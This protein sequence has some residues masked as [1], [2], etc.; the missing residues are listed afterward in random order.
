MFKTLPQ[1]IKVMSYK[2]PDVAAQYSKNSSDEFEAITYSQLFQIQLDVGAGLLQIGLKRG[3]HVGLISDTRK[4]W[5]HADLGLLSIGAIDVPRGCDATTKDLSYIL[6]FAECKIVIT[7]NNTQVA[8]IISIS[9][10]IPTL[11]TIIFFDKIDENTENL[12]K[13]KKLRLIPFDQIISSGAEWRK[14][15]PGAIEAEIE[16]GDT[17]DLASIIFT[18]GTTGEPKGV[19]L[20]HKNFI[21]QLDELNEN[22][23]FY[24]GEKCISVLPV[25]HA[26]ERLCEYV[27]LSQAAAICYSKPIGSVLL[28]DLEKLNPQLFPAV[29][30]VFEALYDGIYRAMKKTGGSTFQAFKFFVTVGKF[31]KRI[32]RILLRQNGRTGYDYIF[33][34]WIFLFIPWIV[35]APF[36]LLGDKLIFKKI[37]S[38]M[39][40]KFR[41]GIAG[42][43]ALPPAIDEFFWTVGINVVEGYGL[44]ETAPVVAVRKIKKPIFGTVG[45][46]IRH[47]QVRIVDDNKKVLPK[48][49][50]GLVQVRGDTVMKGYYKREDL[51][52][53]VIDKD[54]WFDTGDIGYLT[55]TGEIVLKGRKK[56]TIVLRG[57]ENVEPLPIEQKIMESHY[58]STAVVV[59]QDQRNIGA[60]IVP[61]REEI[62]SYAKSCDI[63]YQTYEDLIEH[64]KIYKLI[65]NEINLLVCAKNGFKPFERICSFFLLKKPFE[66]GVELSAKQEIMR[67]K[68]TEIY[69]KEIRKIFGIPE[70][71][72]PGQAA[73]VAGQAVGNAAKE[74]GHAIANMISKVIPGNKEHKD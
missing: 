61:V 25:W 47:V 28:S 6:S 48:G 70:P 3:E 59:G 71:S 57:G 27:V 72:N 9:E 55:V 24:P 74:A 19:M 33:S 68:L 54:G 20:T 73:L 45:R 56:D 49:K 34:A 11:E 37:R 64:E 39:G 36:Y 44:T 2:H 43:G 51:T 10:K 31:H 15:N 14:Q 23:S 35:T 46:P 38:K 26:F 4:E 8:K 41:A 12:A 50:R 17:N 30:R 18:S 1:I 67:Y 66:V 13:E 22:M 69:A 52:S 58:I 65:E 53:K 32:T 62:I 5:Q 60:L 42:G 21:T 16:K 40:K 7:E 63:A 29:P